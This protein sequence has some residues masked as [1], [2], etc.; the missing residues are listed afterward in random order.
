LSVTLD[1]FEWTVSDSLLALFFLFGVP[2]LAKNETMIVFSIAEVIGRQLLT[3]LTRHTVLS[4]IKPA[5]HILRMLLPLLTH[6]CW[7]VSVLLL[8]TSAPFLRL[9]QPLLPFQRLLIRTTTNLT[10][11]DD[12]VKLF[13]SFILVVQECIYSAHRFVRTGQ[14]R[15]VRFG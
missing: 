12:F 13:Q 4:Y 8:L 6:D 9:S 3:N 5:G 2:G 1:C 14:N 15:L 11:L 7:A 10:K